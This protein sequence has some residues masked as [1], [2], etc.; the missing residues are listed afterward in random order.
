MQRFSLLL[1][2]SFAV[3]GAAAAQ[4]GCAQCKVW[5]EDQAPFQ[6]YGNTT[7]SALTA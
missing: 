4:D 2:A 7:M 6:I 1:L 3:G 5:N